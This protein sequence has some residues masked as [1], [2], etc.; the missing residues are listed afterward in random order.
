MLASVSMVSFVT[1]PV[2]K[3]A[4]LISSGILLWMYLRQA[5][6][7]TS[8]ELQGRMMIFLMTL[9]FWSGMVALYFLGVMVNW[10]WWR[11]ISIGAVFY[12]V[13]ATIVWLDLQV[14]FKTFRRALFPMFWLGAEL[15]AIGWWLSTSVWVSSFIVTVLGMMMVHSTRHVWLNSW[16]P[17]R[18]KRYLILGITVLLSVL[19]TAKW[20]S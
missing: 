13:V 3:Y 17:G 15:A 8:N 9:S 14:A 7:P 1:S 11:V 16:K 5:T 4:T 10:P 12:V 2:A 20:M 6:L 19:L 18:G